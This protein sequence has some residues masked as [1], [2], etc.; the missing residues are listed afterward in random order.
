MLIARDNFKTIKEVQPTLSFTLSHM[1]GVHR[2]ED[3][4]KEKKLR[5]FEILYKA[6]GQTALQ[7]LTCAMEMSK[8]LQVADMHVSYKRGN[9][10]FQLLT[11]APPDSV[12]EYAQQKGRFYYVYYSIK[13]MRRNKSLWKANKELINQEYNESGKLKKF[14]FH[15]AQNEYLVKNLSLN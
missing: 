4:F 8:K 3:T 10:I 12:M 14:V 11:S 6:T 9:I 2:D 13:R 7:I 15:L 1:D 5:C